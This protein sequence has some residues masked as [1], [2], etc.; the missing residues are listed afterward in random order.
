MNSEKSSNEAKNPA[1]NKAGVRLSSIVNLISKTH[2][3]SL[4]E[5]RDNW[6]NN[7]TLL[8][9]E[10]PKY[11]FKRGDALYFKNGYDIPMVAKII[12]FNKESF[13]VYLDWDCYWVGLD[14]S[15]RIIYPKFVINITEKIKKLGNENDVMEKLQ[16]LQQG[17]IIE[18][19]YRQ[20][21]GKSVDNTM[22]F[23]RIWNKVITEINK[24]N[25]YPIIRNIKQPNGWATNNGGFWN[26]ETYSL[27]N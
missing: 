21:C 23:Y 15:E 5:R 16:Q 11:N 7:N 10:T 20:T 19:G 27:Q 13:E 4:Y 26:V 8:V 25:I 1:L 18:I 6:I 2:D 9:A 22:I 24:Q 3:E 12:G 14:I 17:K